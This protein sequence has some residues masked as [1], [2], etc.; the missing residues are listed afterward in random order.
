MQTMHGHLGF[1]VATPEDRPPTRDPR[2]AGDLTIV[3]CSGQ[4]ES[5]DVPFGAS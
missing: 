5:T 1:D 3:S 4:H 2:N